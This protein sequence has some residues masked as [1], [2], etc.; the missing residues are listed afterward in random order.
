MTIPHWLL[1]HLKN[2]LLRYLLFHYHTVHIVDSQKLID[3]P[4]GVKSQLFGIRIWSW[5][6]MK[7]PY[8]W[9]LFGTKLAYVVYDFRY[10]F[11]FAGGGIE[12]SLTPK[13][14]WRNGVRK[15]CCHSP[16]CYL[17]T[18]LTDFRTGS[19]PQVSSGRKVSQKLSV[20]LILCNSTRLFGRGGWDYN[21]FKSVGSFLVLL[22][23]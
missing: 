8:I 4:V 19:A 14:R 7:L 9:E 15:P 18:A 23:A 12:L 21:P 2:R 3:K 11:R 17:Y 6:L 22:N 1:V 16:R 13:P 20:F 5:C 10:Q